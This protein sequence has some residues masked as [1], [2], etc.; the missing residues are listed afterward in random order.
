MLDSKYGRAY[1]RLSQAY[2]S[3]GRYQEAIDACDKGLKLNPDDD[4]LQQTRADAQDKMRGKGRQDGPKASSPEPGEKAAGGKSGFDFASMMQNPNLMGMASSMLSNPAFSEMAK[5]AMSN[6]E[7]I[8]KM[9]G[10]PDMAKMAANFMGSMGGKGG[11]T[12]GSSKD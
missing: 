10:N 6:P 2:Y 5:K 9:M 1:G 11:G 4:S 8:S 7:A 12:A 3:A